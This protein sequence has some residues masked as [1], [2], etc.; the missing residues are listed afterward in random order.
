MSQNAINGCVNCSHK[1]V[2][3]REHYKCTEKLSQPNISEPDS[4]FTGFTKDLGKIMR[5]NEG[6]SFLRGCS[7]Q[8][9][10]SGKEVVEFT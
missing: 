10:N 2:V 6:N 3:D 5:D 1:K 7:C 9:W 8:Y 4:K